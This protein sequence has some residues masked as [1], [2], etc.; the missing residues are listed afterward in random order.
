MKFGIYTNLN[1]DIDCKV[2]KQFTDTLDKKG[3][4]YLVCDNAKEYYPNNVYTMSKVVREC[5]ILVAF[6]GDGTMLS[7]MSKCATHNKPIL[8]VNMGKIGFLTELDKTQI[9]NSVDRILTG[10]YDIEDRLMLK[11][12]VDGKVFYSLNEVLLSSIDNC[13]I[14]TVAI[15]IDDTYTDKIR[16][17]GVL[18]STPTGST[19]YS[20]SC[21]GPI[22][23]PDVDA[24]LINMVCPHTLHSCPMVVNGNSKISLS[25]TNTSGMKLVVD[26]KIVAKFHTNTTINVEKN[27]FSAK[28]IRLNNINFYQK[29]LHKLSN[30]GD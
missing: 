29:L 12:S 10:E 7:V 8:G 21:G 19:A 26:G 20:L 30:W 23:S 25:T 14:V 24:L 16:G 27:A 5:D 3:A 28:F 11:V 17:D 13:H 22:L 1:R 2:C 9:D 4:S 15:D 18:V 6:G